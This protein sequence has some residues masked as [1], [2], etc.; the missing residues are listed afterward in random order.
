MEKAVSGGSTPANQSGSTRREFLGHLAALSAGLGVS[1]PAAKGATTELPSGRAVPASKDHI[2][3]EVNG[4]VHI[5]ERDPRITLLDALRE[6]VPPVPGAERSVYLKIRDRASYEF[7]L[8]SAAVILDMDGSK[9]RNA[10]IAV[11]GVGTKP[12][13]LPAVAKALQGQNSSP[14]VFS[15]AARLARDGARPLR[16]NAFKVDLLERTVSRALKQAANLA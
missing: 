3:L 5:I 16:Y 2:E 15:Q 4:R 13:A 14:D 8:P 10:R 7:A 1:L 12:W 6:R 11:G 9:I